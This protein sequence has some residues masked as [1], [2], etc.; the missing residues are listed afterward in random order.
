MIW[1][2]SLT[3]SCKL[4]SLETGMDVSNASIEEKEVAATF[5]VLLVVQGMTCNRMRVSKM[6]FEVRAGWACLGLESTPTY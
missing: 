2:E 4:I 1:K 6:G 5:A 3:T